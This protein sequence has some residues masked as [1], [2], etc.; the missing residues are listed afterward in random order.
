MLLKKEARQ[1]VEAYYKDLYREAEKRRVR[2][3]W[4]LARLKL[5]S[6]RQAL[7]KSDKIAWQEAMSRRQAEPSSEDPVEASLL[8]QVKEGNV[9]LVNVPQIYLT[10]VVEEDEIRDSSGA[11]N[12]STWI[13]DQVSNEDAEDAAAATSKATGVQAREALVVNQSR[14]DEVTFPF[15]VSSSSVSKPFIQNSAFI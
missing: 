9:S 7:W 15:D 3:K 5:A 2:A 1:E 14:S 10:K 6:S 8:F 12:E 13:P 11:S 4:R